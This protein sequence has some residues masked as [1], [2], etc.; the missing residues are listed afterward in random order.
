M[1]DLFID[2]YIISNNVFD[3]VI[4]FFYNLLR[5]ICVFR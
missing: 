5:I 1:I 3:N 2:Y 4:N